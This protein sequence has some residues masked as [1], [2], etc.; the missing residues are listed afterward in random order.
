[1]EEIG[2]KVQ[3]VGNTW[4]QFL[5]KANQGQLQV[6]WG[7]WVGDYPD[8]ENWLQLLYGPNGTPGP[9]YANYDNPEYNEL[10]ETIRIM[11]DSPERRALI[12]RMNNLALR[13]VPWRMSFTSTDYVLRHRWLKNFMYADPIYNWQKYLRVDM[14]D[15]ARGVHPDRVPGKPGA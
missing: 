10:Y 13:D 1:M 2:L 11:S 15:R 14:A 7:G 5:N 9:N 12:H 4:P 8:E 3:L 6:Y